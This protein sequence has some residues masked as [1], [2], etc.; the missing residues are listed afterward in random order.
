MKYLTDNFLQYFLALSLKNINT[1]VDSV[2]SFFISHLSRLDDDGFN[3]YWKTL[4]KLKSLHTI[5]F[6]VKYTECI[7]A[8]MKIIQNVRV[9]FVQLKE[10][11]QN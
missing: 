8:K 7:L 1:L 4:T 11:H 6:R 3:V 5:D 10:I 9:S 2:F